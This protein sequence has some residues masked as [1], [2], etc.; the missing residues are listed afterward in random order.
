MLCLQVWP[1]SDFPLIKVGKL[2]LDRNPG[3]Y[4]VD[5]EQAAYSPAHL[6]PGIEPS[7]DKMLQ[8][9]PQ[10]NRTIARLLIMVKFPI[11]RNGWSHT[12]FAISQTCQ[13]LHIKCSIH[14]CSSRH[15]FLLNNVMSVGKNN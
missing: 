12:R 7:P 13:H 5:V 14:G 1:H 10:I 11:L 2:V 3:N 9:L 15:E 8:Q 6:V 4:F